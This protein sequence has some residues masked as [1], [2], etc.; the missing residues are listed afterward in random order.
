MARTSHLAFDLGAES[1]RAVIGTLD[2]DRLELQEVHRL[3]HA[4]RST[5]GVLRWDIDSIT[6][7]VVDSLGLCARIGLKAPLSSVGVDA[8][9]VDFALL[10]PQLRMI[11]HPMCYRE[12]RHTRGFDRL[13]ADP[14]SFRLYQETGVH[15][16]PINTACQLASLFERNPPLRTNAHRLL[17]IPD[18][19]HHFLSGV[20]TNELTIASTSQLLRADGRGW[21]THVFDAA[22]VPLHLVDAPI[23]PA[24]VIGSL[25]PDL[26]EHSGLHDEVRVIAPAGHD[27]ACAVAAAP[28]APDSDWCYLSSGTWSLLGVE[29]HAPCTSNDA[30]LSGFTNEHGASGTVLFHRNLT[31][32]WILQECRREMPGG[33]DLNRYESLAALAA[34]EQPFRTRI[35]TQ[36]SVFTSQGNMIH[37]IRHHARAHGDPA[38]ESPGQIARACLEGLAMQYRRTIAL[39]ESI[40]SR[41]L[42]VIHVIGGGSKNALLNQMT[43]DATGKRVIAGPTEATAAGNVLVQGLG[44]GI[45]AD[46]SHLRRISRASCSPLEYLPLDTSSW[47]LAAKRYEDVFA[48]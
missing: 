14:G 8:W 9:G 25:L 43:A 2:H 47:D 4:P 6:R 46:I 39:L 40:L 35:D 11:E 38:P 30:F 37:K 19:I 23:A 3:H 48:M 33:S 42:E 34:D 5:D 31:G 24:S 1:C 27:T 29:R 32:L 7:F 36:D 44:S 22:G 41:R 12:P 18:L 28:A 17:W 26:R 16:S 13:N 45:V 10:N 15:P 21:A 20:A